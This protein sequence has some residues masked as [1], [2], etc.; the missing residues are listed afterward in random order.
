M[1]NYLLNCVEYS[2]NSKN[3]KIGMTL[4]CKAKHNNPDCVMEIVNLANLYCTNYSIERRTLH[5]LQR[6]VLNCISVF[7]IFNINQ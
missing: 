3:M 7:K 2:I 1:S 4:K 5:I 6:T